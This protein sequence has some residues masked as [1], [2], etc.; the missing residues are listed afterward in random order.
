MA[1]VYNSGTVQYGSQILT[2]NSVTYV[3]DNIEVT[4]STNVIERTNELNEASG[5]VA[6]TGFI[7]GSATLQLAASGTAVP[8]LGLTFTLDT[9]TMVILEVGTP[10]SKDSDKKVTIGFRATVA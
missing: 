9:M 8:T 1:A 5:W 10:Y 2:I 3:A 4:K 7:T 6:S